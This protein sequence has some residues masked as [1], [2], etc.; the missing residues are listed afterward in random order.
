ML[1]R[2]SLIAG[3]V[4]FAAMLARTARSQT[5]ELRPI[6]PGVWFYQG[7]FPKN[8]QCNSIVIE[9]Q[10]DLVVVDANSVGGAFALQA[11]L[12][13]ASGKPVGAVLLTH[14]HG[15]HLY[16]SAVWTRA[17]A[18]T[19]AH[20]TMQSELARFEPA[21]WRQQAAHDAQMAALGDAP[22]PQIGRAHV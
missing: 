1:T 6:V 11:V 15:D 3:G 5:P 17:G 13:R 18:T 7:D 9:R 12:K 21:R 16:G 10:S 19:I 14:H 2:R 20:R 8:G 22:V 4:S